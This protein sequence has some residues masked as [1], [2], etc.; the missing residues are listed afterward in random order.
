MAGAVGRL[1]AQ[2]SELLAQCLVDVNQLLAERRRPIRRR[3][4]E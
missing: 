1:L 2:C 3:Q 4:Q